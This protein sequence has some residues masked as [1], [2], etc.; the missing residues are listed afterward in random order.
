ME[1]TLK[2]IIMSIYIMK[3]YIIRIWIVSIFIYFNSCTT[4]KFRISNHY[5]N[6][7]CMVINYIK[8]E[9]NE[10]DSIYEKVLIF[11]TNFCGNELCTDELY[12]TMN[13]YVLDEHKK[14]LVVLSSKDTTL[15]K[16][17]STN[18]QIKVKLDLYQNFQKYGFQRPGHYAFILNKNQCPIQYLNITKSFIKWFVSQ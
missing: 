1:L 8:N 14:V 13:K 7:N 17:L 5:D 15:I 6:A 10:S 18:S 4:Y 16:I 2:K 12:E 3:Y 9:F 11:R